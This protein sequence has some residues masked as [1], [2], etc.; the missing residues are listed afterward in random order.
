M[1]RA[2]SHTRWPARPPVLSADNGQGTD[3]NV[4][5]LRERACDPTEATNPTN[6]LAAQ[7]VPHTS[8]DTCDKNVM[9]C[10]N[11]EKVCKELL[12]R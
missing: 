6:E 8:T 5:K 4:Q 1:I 3:P 7:T 9:F 11:L 2:Q 10:D 12:K